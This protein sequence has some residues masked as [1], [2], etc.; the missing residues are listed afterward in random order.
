VVGRGAMTGFQEASTLASANGHGYGG[1]THGAI[2]T[3]S[4]ERQISMNL[5]DW[6]MEH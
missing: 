5:T 6:Q 3:S 2:G 4:S 1:L